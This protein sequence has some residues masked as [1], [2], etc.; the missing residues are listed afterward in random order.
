MLTI[1]RYRHRYEGNLDSSMFQRRLDIE[2]LLA[3]WAELGNSRE[4]GS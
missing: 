1:E 3:A 2:V 4:D